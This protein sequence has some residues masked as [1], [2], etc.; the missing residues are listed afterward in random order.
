MARSSWVRPTCLLLIVSVAC[1]AEEFNGRV[2]GVLDGDTVD[3]LVNLRPRRVRLFGIDAPE[4]GQAFGQR[5]KQAASRLAFGRQVRIVGH[6]SDRY[7]RILGEVILP[8]GT[9]LNMR[10]VEEGFAWQYRQY[11]RDARLAE[12][13]AKARADRRGLWNVPNPIPPWEYRKANIR[14]R[15]VAQGV[16]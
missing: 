11:S 14:S 7:G 6:G 16:R 13:E 10:L 2:V 15:G 8:D 3:V 1:L 5:A 12:L 9:T 4:K